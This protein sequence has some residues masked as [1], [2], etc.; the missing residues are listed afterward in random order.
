M[1]VTQWLP[2]GETGTML[3]KTILTLLNVLILGTA[4]FFFRFTVLLP[5]DIPIPDLTLPTSAAEIER[6]RY[7]ANHVA[8][9]MDCHSTRNWDYF[10]GPIVEGTL[11]GGGEVFDPEH[12]AAGADHLQEHHALCLG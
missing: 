5:R 8:V 1:S 4:F 12:R 11:G 9:C 7:L 3:K 2:T 6:G 10:A